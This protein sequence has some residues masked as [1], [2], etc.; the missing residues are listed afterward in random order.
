MLKRRNRKH[1]E[2]SGIRLPVWALDNQPS[3]VLQGMFRVY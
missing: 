1:E 3:D 2:T